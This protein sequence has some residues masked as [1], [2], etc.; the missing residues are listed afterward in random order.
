MV[1]LNGK[2]PSLSYEPLTSTLNIIIS[3]N[4]LWKHMVHCMAGGQIF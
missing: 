3:I 4:K 2:W 1:I